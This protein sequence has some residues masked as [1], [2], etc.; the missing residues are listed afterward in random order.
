MTT[1]RLLSGVRAYLAT[2]DAAVGHFY[3]D[4]DVEYLKTVTLHDMI[5]SARELNKR[6]RLEE[7]HSRFRAELMSDMTNFGYNT[8][9][10][11]AEDAEDPVIRTGARRELQVRR[12]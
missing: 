10:L 4:S 8:L 11:Q 12:Q 3:S 6:K 7:E 1:E 5:E 9:I 2:T